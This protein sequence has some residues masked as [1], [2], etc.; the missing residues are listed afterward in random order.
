MSEIKGFDA[1]PK[2]E[3]L[4]EYLQRVREL[5]GLTRATLASRAQVNVSTILRIECGKTSVIRPRKAVQERLA[6]ALKIPIEY[7]HAAIS[8]EAFDIPQTNKICPSC[9]NPGTA[10]DIR[11]SQVDAQFCTRCG[12][13]LIDKCLSCS[14]PILLRGRFCPQCGT[15]YRQS[16]LSKQVA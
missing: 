2:G 7:I 12:D 16:S 10:P 15:P 6:T 1:V 3:P 4:G 11:W 9:W 13:Q 8:Q 5:R 14:E